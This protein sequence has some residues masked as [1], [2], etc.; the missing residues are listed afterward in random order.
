MIK[1][2]FSNRHTKNIKRQFRIDT[3]EWWWIHVEMFR[4][5]GRGQWQTSTNWQRCGWSSWQ[6]KCSPRNL[7]KWEDAWPCRPWSSTAGLVWERCV[8]W[9]C[10]GFVCPSRK[11]PVEAQLQQC[12]PF[13]LYWP[14]HFHV[15]GKTAPVH[16]D[17]GSNNESFCCHY[18]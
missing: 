2:C 7:Q 11:G 17:R 14:N 16:L 13:F 6:G 18:G 12:P 8:R 15:F 10:L 9:G 5:Q 3:E 1:T 4:R